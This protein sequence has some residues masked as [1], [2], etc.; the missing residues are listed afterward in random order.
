M[1]LGPDA[2]DFWLGTW[3]V[4]W[5][6]GGHGANTIRRILDERVIEESFEGR[7]PDGALR[8]RSLSVLD[9]TDGRWHQ[10][11]VDSNG[12]YIDLVGVDVDGRIGFQRETTVAGTPVMQRMVWIDVTNDAMRWVWQRSENGGSDWEVSWEIR[13]RRV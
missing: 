5:E 3:E 7:D 2:L 11:W 4:S 13:Y 9:E 8:G 6:G 1:T 12:S 10:T